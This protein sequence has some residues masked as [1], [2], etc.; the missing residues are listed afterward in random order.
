MKKGLGEMKQ[1]KPII[2]GTGEAFTVG[3]GK[4]VAS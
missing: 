4:G 3:E 2:S 1:G